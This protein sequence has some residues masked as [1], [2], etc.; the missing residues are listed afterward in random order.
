MQSVKIGDAWLHVRAELRPGGRN[1]VYVNSLGTDFRI[2]DGVVERLGAAS[3]GAL[4]YDLRGHGLS[5]LG[6]P[7]KRIA[8]HVADLAGL[9]DAFGVRSAAICGVSVGGVIA[10]GLAQAYPERVERLALCDTGAKIGTDASWN[11]RIAAVKQGGV[12]AVADGVME[13]W[14]PPTAEAADVALAR[15]MLTRTP[16]AG[17]IATCVA[18]RD[19]DLTEAARGVK[20]PTLCVAGS[21]DGST[22]P[23]LVRGLAALVPDAAYFEIDGAGHLPCLQTPAALAERLVAFLK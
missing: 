2:W 3:F 8:D 6:T 22:P 12:A 13:R 5:D 11:S 9:M 16:A 14:F 20:A 18:L 7:P 21:L 10:L 1:V 23:A 17:Y 15:N 4:R 19:S